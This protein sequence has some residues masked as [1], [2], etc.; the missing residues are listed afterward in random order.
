MEG[1]IETNLL[2][3]AP[4][5][6]DGKKDILDRWKKIGFTSGLKEGGMI[7]WRCAKSMNDMAICLI[8]K[9]Q[10]SEKEY[11]YLDYISVLVFPIIRRL[12]SG[13]NR[14]CAFIEPNSLLSILEGITVS[15]IVKYCHRRIEATYPKKGYK[16]KYQRH[17]YYAFIWYFRE[18]RKNDEEPIFRFLYRLKKDD[19]S[20]E[21]M[22]YFE[23]GGGFDLEAAVVSTCCE[24]IM[25]KYLNSR[26]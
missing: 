18:N 13:K 11:D 10:G 19:V 1:I 22:R 14:M 8:E 21:N 12:L 5:K 7:E 6:K 24:I 26:K 16:Q 4:S 25:E 3:P 9:S 15:E 2:V 17:M 20:A 23:E